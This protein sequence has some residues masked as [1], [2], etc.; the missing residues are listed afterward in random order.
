MRNITWTWAWRDEFTKR[1]KLPGKTVNP[2][3]NLVHNNIL[4]LASRSQLEVRPNTTFY[5][6][7]IE[8]LMED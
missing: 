6:N 7:A 1:T 8:H 2:K 5:G 4:I 3:I